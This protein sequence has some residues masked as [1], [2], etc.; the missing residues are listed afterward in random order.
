MPDRPVAAE[1]GRVNRLARQDDLG[2]DDPGNLE[3][4]IGRRA[5]VDGHEHHAF[6]ERAPHR[7]DPFRAVLAPDRD[8][9]SA[10]DVCRAQTAGESARGIGQLAITPRPRP[11]AVV[12]GEKLRVLRGAA[13]D[14]R[15]EVEQ[16]TSRHRS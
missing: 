6:E 15:E 5:V 9:R 7:G 10:G 11:V 3:Q 14:V 8:R 16:R 2:V 12:I 4:K 1:V 13:G